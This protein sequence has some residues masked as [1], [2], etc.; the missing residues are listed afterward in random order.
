MA[1]AIVAIVGLGLGSGSGLSRPLAVV[2]A[3]VPIV[4]KS[5]V[6]VVGISRRLGGSGRLS[7]PFAVVVATVGI[8]VASIS[9]MTK[10]IVA[11][12]RI[13]RGLSLWLRGAH[14]QVSHGKKN[15][16]LDHAACAAWL[17]CPH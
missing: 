11:V 7:R 12:V 3:S 17:K 5:V 4:A 15:Q 2:M 13:S 14:G 6:A 8:G 1:K 16:R 10:A 9:V